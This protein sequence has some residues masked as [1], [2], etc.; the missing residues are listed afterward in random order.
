[1]P[2]L[3]GLVNEVHL[4]LSGY[5]QKQDA[6]SSLAATITST[7]TTFTVADGTVLSRG[8]VEIDDELIW[9]A[10]F[11]RTTA[12]ATIPAYGRGFRG[13]TAT[14]HTAGA[15]VTIAPTFPRAVI[16][17]SI[18]D[19]IEALYPDLFATSETSF[20][21]VATRSTYAMPSD[22]V[23]AQQVT[24]QTI[25]PSLEW[26]PVR[27]YRVDTMANGTTWPTGKT[28]SLYDSPIP[29]RTVQITYTHP[30]TTLDYNSDDFADT[31]LPAS[32]KEVVVLG[33]AY[34]MAS[35]LDAGRVPA[36]SVEADAMQQTNPIGSGGQVSRLLFGMYQQ[37]L[38]GEIRRQQEQF[39]A[40]I[41]FTR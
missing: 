33:A 19:A 21:F 8:L 38:Q 37:R 7:A 17:S 10:S 4:R 12:T 26:L 24:W 1:M 27:K 30:A 6:A 16:A 29:G 32:A 14:G 28:I 40:R 3:S 5:T 41:R 22:T 20:P 13:S 18:N 23:D 31:G 2:T 25:G 11:D 35:Y 39:Q 34:R 9:V 15:R 36:Q